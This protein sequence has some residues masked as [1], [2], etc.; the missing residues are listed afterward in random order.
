MGKE[1]QTHLGKALHAVL[2]DRLGQG[3][4]LL[5]V[6]VVTFFTGESILDTFKLA[7]LQVLA[8]NS[9]ALGHV[10]LMHDLILDNNFNVS[11]AFRAWAIKSE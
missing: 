11:S 4:S 1:F 2:F 9:C 10:I 8:C 3:R 7:E 5:D 6:L